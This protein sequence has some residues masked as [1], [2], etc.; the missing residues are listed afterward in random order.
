MNFCQEI[1]FKVCYDYSEIEDKKNQYLLK[2][3]SK[4]CKTEGSQ[5]GFVWVVFLKLYLHLHFFSSAHLNCWNL[6]Y[7]SFV[8]GYPVT[9]SQ[10]Q[11]DRNFSK[12]HYNYNLLTLTCRKVSAMLCY[13]TDNFPFLYTRTMCGW[14]IEY[15]SNPES[16]THIHN[17]TI[18][19]ENVSMKNNQTYDGRM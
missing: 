8:P 13:S 7:F 19:G 17:Y 3:W 11:N 12:G 5:S 14:M 15:M 10:F 4:S 9:R 18:T 6:R 1:K 16:W 2:S